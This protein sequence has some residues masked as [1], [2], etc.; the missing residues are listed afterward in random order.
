MQPSN[1]RQRALLSSL[2]ALQGGPGATLALG[3]Q[4]PDL[5]SVTW[6]RAA[7]SSDAELVRAGWRIKATAKD[8]EVACR[9]MGRLST[10]S[11]KATE[12]KLLGSLLGFIQR[13]LEAYPSSL[14]QDEE[15]LQVAEGKEELRV[16]VQV[17]RALVSEKRALHGSL[18]VVQKWLQDVEA[19]KGLEQVYAGIMGGADDTESF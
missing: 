14:Q 9:A 7:A 15:E 10:P 2:E 6:L 18:T 17:L 16:R 4:G 13:A 5:T 8:V 12:Q 3:P 19:G 11:S 1:A